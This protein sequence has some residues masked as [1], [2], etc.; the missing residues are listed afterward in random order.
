MEDSGDR[1]PWKAGEA[2]GWRGRDAERGC[3]ERDGARGLPGR[4]SAVRLKDGW[5]LLARMALSWRGLSS[6]SKLAAWVGQKGCSVW[7]LSGMAWHGMA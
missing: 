5:L 7:C 6:Q 2:L 4:A 1:E 3:G